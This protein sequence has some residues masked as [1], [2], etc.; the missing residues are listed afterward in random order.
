LKK[1]LRIRHKYAGMWRAT[2]LRHKTMKK[3]LFSAMI[4]AFAL[5]TFHAMATPIT[6]LHGP[7]TI[8]WTVSEQNKDDVPVYSG[9][10]KTNITGVGANKA[11]NVLQVDNYTISSANGNFGNAQL[12]NLLANSFNVKF[13]AGTHLVTD[14][15]ALFVVD[16]TGTNEIVETSTVL[17]LTV[18]NSFR[19]GSDTITTTTKASGATRVDDV[20]GSGDETIIVSYND[21]KLVTAD[22]TTSTFEF[23]GQ[24][25]FARTATS[26]TS[27]KDVFTVK[28]SGFFTV[29]GAGFGVI[30]AKDANIKG[31]I[32]GSIAGT[33]TVDVP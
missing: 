25:S 18:T 15:A 27:N 2:K 28:E 22:G 19:G 20:T 8:T 13:P 11:T 9:D 30:R 3:L 23:V 14:G 24:S 12:L 1:W 29:T 33:E 21:S 31:T 32:A 26:T 7:V 5:M 4:P 16:S 17:T 6:P 10:G